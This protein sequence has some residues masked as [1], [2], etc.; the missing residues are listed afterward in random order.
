MTTTMNILVC[1]Q[2]D[3][4]L[5]ALEFRMNK[6]GYKTLRAKSGAEALEIMATGEAN[7]MVTDADAGDMS[8]LD[9]IKQV[10]ASNPDMPIILISKMEDDE[11]ML[12]AFRSG[13]NDFITKPF[14]PVEL[15]LRIRKIFQAAEVAS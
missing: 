14:N 5:T 1:E 9:L 10:N 11:E 15:V 2:E 13:A 12:D 3:I 6:Q 8:G 7:L 4:L